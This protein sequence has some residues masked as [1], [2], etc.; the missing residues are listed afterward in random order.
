MFE[1]AYLYGD[2]LMDVEEKSGQV[3]NEKDEDEAH[4]NDGHVVLLTTT[5]LVGGPLNFHIGRFIPPKKRNKTLIGQNN[6]CWRRRVS[7]PV[8]LA[9]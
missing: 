7:I 8:P 5:R 3:A 1:R 6:Y 9:C 2:Q 4:E